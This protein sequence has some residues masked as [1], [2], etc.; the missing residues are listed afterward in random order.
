MTDILDPPTPNLNEQTQ[1]TLGTN[2]PTD[3]EGYV[4]TQFAQDT[5][6]MTGGWTTGNTYRGDDPWQT[7][8][9]PPPDYGYP[10]QPLGPMC[11]PN[12]HHFDCRHE[13]RCRCQMTQRRG[14]QVLPQGL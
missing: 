4:Q 5:A 11:S 6:Q 13:Q 9:T 3:T 8:A 1:T 12:S 7:P 10:G 14:D 2:G